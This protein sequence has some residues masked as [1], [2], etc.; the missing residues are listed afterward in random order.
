MATIASIWAIAEPLL[1]LFQLF[2]GLRFKYH[3]KVSERQF[4]ALSKEA[5]KELQ[6]H[7]TH[8]GANDSIIAAEEMYCRHLKNDIKQRDG[9]FVFLEGELHLKLL[10]K[11]HLP[12]KNKVDGF[13]IKSFFFIHGYSHTFNYLLFVDRVKRRFGVKNTILHYLS[14]PNWRLMKKCRNWMR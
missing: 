5:F 8:F 13:L 4:D 14:I 2:V 7:L 6:I 10:K 3:T 1:F 11:F 9:K 12:S